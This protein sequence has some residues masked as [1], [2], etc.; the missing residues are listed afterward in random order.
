VP[1]D[2]LL[3]NAYVQGICHM[4]VGTPHE[5]RSFVSMLVPLGVR[6]FYLYIRYICISII[7]LFGMQTENNEI[8]KLFRKKISNKTT[9]KL[10]PN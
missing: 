4:H 3:Y 9:Q 1:S 6:V 7:I 10:H 8:N 5:A 2:S